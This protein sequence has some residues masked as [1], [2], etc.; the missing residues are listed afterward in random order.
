MFNRLI[1]YSKNN[2]FFLFGPRG[3]GKSTFLKQKLPE[4]DYLW[5]N[6]LNSDLERRLSTKPELLKSIIKE[7]LTTQG[8]QKSN[9]SP[10]FIVIDEVQ[11][12]PELLDVV[13]DCI[14]S[15]KWNFALTGSSARKL[16]KN[17]ANLLAGRAFTYTAHPL[18]YSELGP[19]FKINDI[20]KWGALPKIFSL[21]EDDKKDFLLSYVETYF[22]EEIVSEQIIRNVKPFRYFLEVASQSNA[23]IINN[24][25]IARDIGVET[26]TVQNYFE[27]LEDTL[28]GF[29]LPPYHNSIRRRQRQNSKFYYFDTGVQRTLR[30][31]LDLPLQAQ[32]FEYGDLFEQFFINEVRRLITYQKL[33]WNIS[34]LRTQDGVEIDLIIERPGLPTALIEIK[35]AQE[36]HPQNLEGHTGFLK[37]VRDFPNAEAFVLSQDPIA[38][39]ENNIRYL[40]WEQGLQAIGLMDVKITPGRI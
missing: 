25:K 40:P 38:R 32:S 12:V 10:P 7:Y 39:I 16:K 20:L 36:I 22:R 4:S 24:S 21:S 6:L 33:Q 29:L 2:S 28:I 26:S 1:N 13:H 8:Q 30:R 27:I 14:E 19:A 5:I 3:T 34:Y 31:T 18:T 15:E 23:K 17:G 35:S 9:P 11:K 37:L